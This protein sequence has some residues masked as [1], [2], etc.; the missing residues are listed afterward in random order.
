MNQNNPYSYEVDEYEIFESE[1]DKSFGERLTKFRC[2]VCEKPLS[3]AVLCDIRMAY[4]PCRHYNCKIETTYH[5]MGDDVRQE[6]DAD[7]IFQA[8]RDLHIGK[9]HMLPGNLAWYNGKSILIRPCGYAPQNDEETNDV[10]AV[11]MA[12]RRGWLRPYVKAEDKPINKAIAWLKGIGSKIKNGKA[13]EK[14][15][16]LPE[17]GD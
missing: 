1:R 6:T 7:K 8:T 12:I 9:L 17:T 14:D 13:A 11:E 5:V 2:T 3:E 15:E 16:P 10:A 4:G